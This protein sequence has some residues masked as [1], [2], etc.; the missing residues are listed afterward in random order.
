MNNWLQTFAYRINI[1]WEIFIIAGGATM[2]VALFTVN[3]QPLKAALSTLWINCEASRQ[4]PFRRAIQYW[5][6][7]WAKLEKK[8]TLLDYKL[9]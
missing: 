1:G 4:L 3:A 5:K 9:Y 8:Y 2:V 6:A 7:E